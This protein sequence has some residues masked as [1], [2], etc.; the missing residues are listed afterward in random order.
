MDRKR[1]AGHAK[2]SVSLPDLIF[3]DINEQNRC[4]PAGKESRDS[5]LKSAGYL[6]AVKNTCT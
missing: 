5:Y 2:N 4:N 3:M 6:K 1:S